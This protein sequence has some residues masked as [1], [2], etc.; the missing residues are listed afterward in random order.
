MDETKKRWVD[1]LYSVLW[2]YQMIAYSSTGETPFRLAYGTEALIPMEIEEPSRRIEA[3]PYEE[4][5][6][7]AL[8]EDLDLVEE[9]RT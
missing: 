2:G 6:D 3:P 5:N 7:I 1:E 8:C 9:I 4:M